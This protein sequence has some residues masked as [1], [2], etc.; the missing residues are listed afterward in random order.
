MLDAARSAWPMAT[1]PSTIPTTISGR[2][3][4]RLINWGKLDQIKSDHGFRRALQR[5]L[6][7]QLTAT[8]AIGKKK[9]LGCS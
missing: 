1:G 2:P 8:R 9:Q 4:V 5:E 7:L 6:A 3:K